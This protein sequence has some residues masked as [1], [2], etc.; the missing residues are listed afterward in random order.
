MPNIKPV[1]LLFVFADC[2]HRRAVLLGFWVSVVF[3][4]NEDLPAGE[5]DAAH[6][7]APLVG[8]Q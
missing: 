4:E 3:V 8:V 5:C 7:A 6:L 2:E 1:L